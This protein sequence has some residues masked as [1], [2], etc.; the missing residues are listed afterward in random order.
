MHNSQSSLRRLYNN[1]FALPAL[2]FSSLLMHSIPATAKDLTPA[3]RL[4]TTIHP[5]DLKAY[6]GYYRFSG[7]TNSC[8]HITATEKG[9]VLEQEWDG[10]QISFAPKSALEFVNE[11]GD[12]P[13]KFTKENSGAITQVLAFNKDLWIRTNNYKP[14]G[15]AAVRLAPGQLKVLEGKYT[16]QFEQGKDEFI[17]IKATD[18]G[19]VLKQMWDGREIPFIALSD[20]DFYCKAAQF[21]LKFTKDKNG[22]AT[23]VL[24]F[25][26]DLWNKV[27]E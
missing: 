1:I 9:L 21:P 8:L 20:R 26:R 2:L 17:Q 11:D 18:T 16:F 13:L 22:I 15:L 7:D 24:A 12:F 6:E 27:K 10:K 4:D 19:L 3:G 23:Q 25:N 5:Q 14:Q